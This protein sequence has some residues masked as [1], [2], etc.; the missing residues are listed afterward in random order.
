MST[1]N[2]KRTSD[3]MGRK[4]H[5][6]RRSRNGAC[7][8]LSLGHVSRLIMIAT[9]IIFAISELKTIR[10]G[11]NSNINSN[12]N[13]NA[14]RKGLS[15][16]LVSAMKPIRN[17]HVTYRGQTYTIRDGVSTVNELTAR[18]ERMNNTGNN[19]GNHISA[20]GIVWKGQILKPGD[21]LSKAGIKNGDR[22]MILPGD[23]ETKAVDILAV[24]LF[25][26]SSN[27]KAIEEAV[28]KIKKEQPES[29]E[30]MQDM[31]HSFRDALNDLK[32]KDV[33]NFLRN[34][35]DVTY[36][37]LRSWWE[38]PSFRQ[39][40]HDPNRIENYRKVVS[41]NLSSRFLNKISSS[42]SSFSLQKIIESP[43][44]WRREF[45]KVATKAIRFGDT[46]LEGIL[47]LLLDVLKGKGSSAGNNNNNNHQNSDNT[48]KSQSLF[49]QSET[50]GTGIS[51]SSTPSD[52]IIDFSNTITDQ[53]EDPSL[54]NNLLFELSES[55]D[56][57]DED[58][59]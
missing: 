23:K 25:L 4:H 38:N 22:V 3:A 9:F 26:L 6:K 12:T 59:L 5:H 21:D 17:L 56:D 10:Y 24:Y 48:A 45:T 57:Y 32:R 58:D 11:N 30:A 8:S 37:Q 16:V 29:I 19:R 18:F 27:E 43:D 36:H 35:F 13:S 40:L 53:M 1:G 41:T 7:S 15:A 14:V 33:A 34:W 2:R 31:I 51:G 20:K 52:G 54:A 47:D 49:G 44:L 50:V 46:V 39:G 55:D 42:S 28:S